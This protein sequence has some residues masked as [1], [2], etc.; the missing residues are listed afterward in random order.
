[1]VADSRALT[2]GLHR[3]PDSLAASCSILGDLCKGRGRFGSRP[4]GDARARREKAADVQPDEND[5]GLVGCWFDPGRHSGLDRQMSAR[6]GGVHLWIMGIIATTA[7]LLAPAIA[8]GSSETVDVVVNGNTITV[9]IDA[10]GGP[11]SYGF[12]LELPSNQLGNV[13]SVNCPAGSTRDTGAPNG[14]FGC[15]YGTPVTTGSFTIVG[16]S[17]WPPGMTVVTY[18]SADGSSYIQGQ[19]TVVQSSTTDTTPATSLGGTT[20]TTTSAN[21][22]NGRP[23]TRTRGSST[24]ADLAGSLLIAAGALLVLIGAGSEGSQ[25]TADDDGSTQEGTTESTETDSSETENE[26]TETGKTPGPEP[27]LSTEHLPAEDDVV[28]IVGDLSGPIEDDLF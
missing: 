19:P 1:M 27:P 7:L 13:A 9:S 22:G 3:S 10:Q 20:T 12:G 6:R 23:S 28:P 24:S 8:S 18:S 15:L 14:G 4:S 11:P 21:T 26:G 5:L 16:S 2:F 25:T 17:P